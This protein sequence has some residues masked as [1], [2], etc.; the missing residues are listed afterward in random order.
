M[1]LR[2]LWECSRAMK[3]A[4]WHSCRL[5]LVSIWSSN[6]NVSFSAYDIYTDI[7]LAHQYFVGL[8]GS[9][10]PP[11]RP[12]GS[13]LDA[14]QAQVGDLLYNGNFFQFS[15]YKSEGKVVVVKVNTRQVNRNSFSK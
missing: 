6:L 12:D 1:V 15:C 10:S 2:K 3:R 13:G 14:S 9:G 7:V 4:W 11:F 5:S 8:S